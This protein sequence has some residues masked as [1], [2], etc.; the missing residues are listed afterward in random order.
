M[1]GRVRGGFPNRALSLWGFFNV[2]FGAVIGSCWLL[3]IGD[4]MIEG[5]GPVSVVAA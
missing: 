2:G 4:W 5:G 3:L 1:G